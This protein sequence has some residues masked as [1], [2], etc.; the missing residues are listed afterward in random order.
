MLNFCRYFARAIVLLRTDT[1][2]SCFAAHLEERFCTIHCSLQKKEHF[3]TIPKPGTHVILRK[4]WAVYAVLL[5]ILSLAITVPILLI[6][7]LVSSEAQ[8]LRRN[9]RFLHHWYSPFYMLLCGIRV[10]TIGTEKIDPD[11][12]YI[13]VA[14]HSS[15]IDF[16][17]NAIA[18]PGIFRFLAKVELMKIPVFGGVVRRMC[19]TVDRRDG[20]SRMRSVAELRRQLAQG[21]SILIYPEGS[22]NTTGAPLARFYD[23]AFRIALEAGVPIFVQTITNIKS[24]SATA[25]PLD[26]RPG[27][28]QVAWDGPVLPEGKD[29]ETLKNEVRALMLSR[30]N[31]V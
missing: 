26:L 14:N 7:T 18:F 20:A 8:G 22:R 12:A 15:S 19:V 31:N 29:V 30:L 2:R 3:S 23:G 21:W 24:V 13:L 16:I 1:F 27:V 10:R 9:I 6:Q 4:I 28:L 11:A 25:S 5:F 17:V